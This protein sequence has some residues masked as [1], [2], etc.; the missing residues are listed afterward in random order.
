LLEFSVQD[1]GIGISQD[2]QEKIFQSFT[3]ADNSTT[4]QYGG[5]GLGL[6]ICQNIIQM[7]GG[8]ITVESQLD[9]GSTFWFTVNLGIQQE[10][11]PVMTP[12]AT[13]TDNGVIEIETALNHLK[14]A[15][16]LLVEDNEIN[17]ELVLELLTMKQLIIPDIMFVTM[18]KWINPRK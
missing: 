10:K 7:M 6:V 11:S 9:V 18:A 13:H 15:K 3:Q 1:T 5:T 12:L 8:E 14:G 16:I 17:Q 2:Q 4:R